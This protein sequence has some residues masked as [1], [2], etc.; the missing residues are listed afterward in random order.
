ML[1]ALKHLEREVDRL[2]RAFE[3]D[4]CDAASRSYD[5]SGVIIE[6]ERGA[7]AIR[8]TQHCGERSLD[9][10]SVDARSK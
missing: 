1:D 5:A 7:I 10:R 3:R 4:R 2:C 8:I 9:V 6:R